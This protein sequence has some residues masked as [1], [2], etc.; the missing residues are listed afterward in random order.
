MEGDGHYASP[1]RPRHEVCYGGGTYFAN[2]SRLPGGLG[3]RPCLTEVQAPEPA[4]AAGPEQAVVQTKRKRE[5]GNLVPAWS[6]G[7]PSFVTG[8]IGPT[9]SRRGSPFDGGPGPSSSV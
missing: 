9:R 6:D 5:I 3:T 4:P 2:Y 7:S 8:S 1:V